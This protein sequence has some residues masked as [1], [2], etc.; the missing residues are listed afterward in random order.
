MKLNK[1]LSFCAFLIFA[2]AMLFSCK[3]ENDTTGKEDTETNYDQILSVDDNCVWGNGIATKILLDDYAAE[4]SVADCC[5]AI[6]S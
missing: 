5:R 1:T 2:I 4:Q 3:T 6:S